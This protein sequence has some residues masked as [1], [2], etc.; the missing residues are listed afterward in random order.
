M[1]LCHCR[2]SLASWLCCG[3]GSTP[4]TTRQE[5]HFSSTSSSSTGSNLSGIL[6]PEEPS[7]PSERDGI[8]SPKC[9]TANLA[10]YC[11]VEADLGIPQRTLLLLLTLPP[12]AAKV[13]PQLAQARR[14]IEK[15]LLPSGPQVVRYLS[16]PPEGQTKDWILSEMDRMDNYCHTFDDR[17][18]KLHDWKDGRISG[19]VYRE[20]TDFRGFRSIIDCMGRW[21]TGPDEHD[22][23]RLR[24]LLRL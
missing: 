15:K 23:H 9:A 7:E 12:M 17:G 18:A 19:A 5:A 21:W 8:G 10:R 6:E 20:L 13:E 4:P 3:R 2:A 1:A 22:R 16:L 11:P 14:D 24:T